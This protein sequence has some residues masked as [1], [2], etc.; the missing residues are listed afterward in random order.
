[1]R[2]ASGIEGT[3]S[4]NMGRTDDHRVHMDQLLSPLQG[5]PY[6]EKIMPASTASSG[7]AR[8]G[9]HRSP[10]N[11]Q[12]TGKTTFCVKVIFDGNVFKFANHVS[13][14]QLIRQ[15]S[16][17]A[18]RCFHMHMHVEVQI[19]CLSRSEPVPHGCI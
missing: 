2:L 11:F 5:G 6:I 17:L 9:D 8:M 18:I 13:Q 12:T 1:M 3:V 14:I 16:A 19:K 4:L 7:E 15:L 10:V